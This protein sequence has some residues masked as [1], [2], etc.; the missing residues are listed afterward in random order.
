MSRLI[1]EEKYDGQES[2]IFPCEASCGH[3]LRVEWDNDPE[4]RTLFV[5]AYVR[6]RSIK[7]RVKWAWNALRGREVYS[8]GIILNDHS[9]HNLTEYLL[10]KAPKAAN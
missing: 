8:E 4:W 7:E 6:P 5:E 1:E 9:I 10:T 3:Y 2:L